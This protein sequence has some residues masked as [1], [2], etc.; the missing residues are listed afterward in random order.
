M[1]SVFPRAV[2]GASLT[3]ALCAPAFAQVATNPVQKSGPYQVELRVPPVGLY[4]GEETDLEF[5][6]SDTSKTDP[7][8]GAPGVIRAQVKSTVTMPAMAGMPPALPKIHREG[9]PGDYGLVTTFPHGGTYR[10]ALAV[11]PPGDT[12]KPFSVAFDVEVKDADSTRKAAPAPYTLTLVSN[13]DKP[14]A[15]QPTTLTLAVKERATGQTVNAWDLV[16]EQKMHLILVRDDLGA[17]FHEHPT[18]N[19]DGTFTYTFT[20]PTGGKWQVFA[21]A[22]PTG[23]GSQVTSASVTVDGA[24]PT[25]ATLV[26]QSRPTVTEDGVTLAMQTTALPAQ[27]T[28]PLTFSLKDTAGKPVTD[29]QP[30]LGAMGHLILINQDARTFVHSHPDESDP[31]NGKNGSLT[32]LA[33]FPRPG[34][35]RG[36]VQFQRAGQVQTFPFTVRATEVVK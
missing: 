30:W 26:P 31:Q 10:I 8:L 27:K 19:A 1:F 17:F 3:L 29:L 36:W 14:V 12:A 24:A 32:Y 11:T 35:Y 23:A 4:A 20:F 33:R 5:R 21:D 16:H 22:A 6:I 15:G 28:F 25:R 2:L 34:I 7:V 18:L 9:V 13:P